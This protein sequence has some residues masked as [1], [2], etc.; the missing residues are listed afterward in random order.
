[1]TS[2]TRPVARSSRSATLREVAKSRLA[3]PRATRSSCCTLRRRARS[4]PPSPNWPSS[5]RSYSY[6]CRNWCSSQTRLFGC[7]TTY[8]GNFVATTRSIGLP[9]ASSRSAS[10]QRN[11]CVST[12]VPGYHLNGTVTRSVSCPRPRSS[13]TSRSAKI[14]APPRTNGTCGAHTA[15]LIGRARSTLAG[16]SHRLRRR[17]RRVR[18]AEAAFELLD[19]ALLLVEHAQNRGVER[20]LVVCERLDVPPHELAKHRLHRGAD[21]AAHT[22]PQPQGTIRGDRPEALGLRARCESIRRPSARIGSGAPHLLAQ[23]LDERRHVDLLRVGN[24]CVDAVFGRLRHVA[25]V[26]GC[27]AG[28]FGRPAPLRLALA[29]DRTL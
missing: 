6:A 9:S 16:Q 14:S 4:S 8:D 19:L 7:R 21:A 17:S 27:P 23:P 29:R 3:S 2:A 11:A 25:M 28:P 1:M 20:P 12:R 22:R 10:R 18:L 26:L 15:I 13:S 24:G 5:V